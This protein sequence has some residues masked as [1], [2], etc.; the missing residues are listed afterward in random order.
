M[1]ETIA[2]KPG[3]KREGQ[4]YKSLLVWDI[5]LKKTDE[6]H[7]LQ[8]KDIKEH[9]AHY[10]ITAERHSIKRDIDDITIHCSWLQL[11]ASAVNHVLINLPIK[12]QI[13]YKTTP[14]ICWISDPIN[15]GSL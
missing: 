13:L 9:L 15:Q 1:E 14:L 4:K 10:G 6:N 3:G 2:K 7:A 11:S 5:L 12:T 8:L